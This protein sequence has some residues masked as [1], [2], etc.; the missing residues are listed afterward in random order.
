MTH[1]H[2][3]NSGERVRAHGEKESTKAD[4]FLYFLTDST[5]EQ[6]P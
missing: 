6:S 1:L 5:E 3:I 2:I 4:Q